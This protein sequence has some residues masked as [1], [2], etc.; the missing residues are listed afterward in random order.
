[1]ITAILYRLEGEPNVTGESTFSDVPAG[2]WYTHAVIWAANNN[3]ITGYGSGKFG[4]E[5]SITREQLAALIYR[6]AQYKGYDTVTASALSA[7]YDADQVSGWAETAIKW[8][9]GS[10][11]ITG[12]PGNVLDP[13]GTAT[14]AEIAA[15]L[16]RFIQ[17]YNLL[18]P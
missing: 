9:V 13:K 2:I 14:R 18:Q 12:K 17:K 5:D 3:I 16:A 7:F 6:Y 11:I 4:S 8:A 10:G 1:M 15:M